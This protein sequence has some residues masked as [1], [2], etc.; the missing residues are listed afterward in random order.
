MTFNRG[1]IKRY[2]VRSETFNSIGYNPDK[3]IL[4]LEFRDNRIYNYFDVSQ[5][6]YSDMM[7]APS[8]GKFFHQNILDQ[9]EYEQLP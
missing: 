4:Q 3:K 6:L 7:I 9:Y 8:K 1:S 2:Q 5:S